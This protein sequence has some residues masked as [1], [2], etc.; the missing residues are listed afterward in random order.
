MAIRRRVLK[1]RSRP[2]SPSSTRSAKSS[3]S[4]WAS[5]NALPG[6][7]APTNGRPHAQLRKAIQGFMAQRY[8]DADHQD[9]AWRERRL[10]RLARGLLAWVGQYIITPTGSVTF[11]VAAGKH[12]YTTTV[13]INHPNANRIAIQ[14]GAL[15]GA[16]PTP[17]NISVTGFHS[18]TD[19]TNQ[20]IYLRSVHATELSFTGGATGFRAF[21]GGCTL[22]YLLISGSQSGGIGIH[23]FEDI[24]VDGISI[25]GFG[26]LGI[27]ADTGAILCGTSL[28]LTICFCG[29]WRS[30]DRFVQTTPAST[31]FIS[32]SHHQFA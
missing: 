11:M 6:C 12:T 32:C 3:R 27:R 13:E 7:V 10:R 21:R 30:P 16:S 23:T 1:V 4:S 31:Y 19:G 5:D 8:I 9:G 15:L 14:G 22:R 24:W 17:P 18:S 20:I 25:W 28:S 29:F 2:A 26:S